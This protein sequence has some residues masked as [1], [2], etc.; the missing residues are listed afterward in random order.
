MKGWVLALVLSAA[1]FHSL[2]GQSDTSKAAGPASVL[3]GIVGDTTRTPLSQAEVLAMRTRRKVTT[4]ARGIF[5]FVLPPGE[6]VFLV[7]RV[8]FLPQTFEATLVAG[9][10]IRLGVVLG[11]APVTLPE[12][13]VEAEGVA[14]R[15]KLVEFAQRMVSTGAPRSSFLTRKDIESAATTQMVY[16][17]A[18]TGLKLRPAARGRTTVG[19]PRGTS[20]RTP[21][22][23][24]YVDGAK[25]Q[26]DFDV[27]SLSPL[28][29]EAI[30]VY[31]STAERPAQYNATGSECVV[32]IWLRDGR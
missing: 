28:D 14:Y 12:L 17:L 21:R 1:P 13:V 23:E 24:F 7:R 20:T 9:D 4:D 8:G 5:V 15:G 18:T 32:L 25:M 19:C 27:N 6:E 11:R 30:E 3:I 16:L 26:G 10:T 22:V 31:R 29:V 2:L